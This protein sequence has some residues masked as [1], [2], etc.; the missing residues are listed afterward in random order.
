M[1]HLAPRAAFVPL[2][3]CWVCGGG[4]LKRFH[5]CRLDFSPYATQDAELH[6]YTDQ[7]VWFVRCDHCGFAQPESLPALPRFFERMYDQHWSEEWVE[8]E[9]EAGYKDLIFATVLGELDRRVDPRSRRLLDIGAHAGRFL[10]LSRQ[11]G[12]TV[13]GVE[14]NP[15]TAAC[16]ARRAG[17]TVHAM[18]ARDLASKGLRFNA[19]TLIDVLEHIPDPVSLLTTIARLL[20][21]GGCVGIKVPCGPG[22]WRK[23]RLLSALKPSR[24]MALADNLVHVNH[25]SVRSLTMALERAGFRNVTI[26]T[27]PPELLSPGGTTLAHAAENALRLAVY[28]AARLPGAV[29]SPLALNLQAYARTPSAP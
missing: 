5:D 29:H 3:H 7:T 16:A 27:A 2:A 24:K 18:N 19:V 22:Q 21:P 20:E 11:R 25:F 26:R 13:E 15:R 6:A 12:W 10:H 14:V 28:A 23:E 4:Q 9:F 1:I 8:S 17:A